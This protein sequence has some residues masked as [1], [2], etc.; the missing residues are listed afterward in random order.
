MKFSQLATLRKSVV[1]PEDFHKYDAY[2]GYEHFTP[3][4]LHFNTPGAPSTV[5]SN[6]QEFRP[7]DTIYGRLRPYFRKVGWSRQLTGICSTDFWVLQPHPGV[8]PRFVFYVAG[9][10]SFTELANSSSEGTRMP[11]ASWAVVKDFEVPNF[12]LREQREIAATL[13]ALDD[14]IESNQLAI[15]KAQK[16][17]DALFMASSN[18]QKSISAVGTITMGTSPKGETLNEIGEGVPFYQGTR[19]FG[20]R[21]P[22]LR[23][24][25]ERPIRRAQKN[26][27]LLS[28][29]APVGE[30]NRALTDCCIGRGVAAIHNDS[31]PSTLYYAMRA[32]A[33]T[34]DR[35]QGEGTVF[36]SVNKKDVHSAMIRWA[37]D[38][39]VETLEPMLAALDTRIESLDREIQ[40]L[41]QLRDALLPE[42]LAGRIKAE[43]IEK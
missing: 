41:S 9:S 24:W 43:G 12:S 42:L 6:K 21:F 39:S 38:D 23:V 15:T 10:Q 4:T 7:G 16:L 13:G 33:S 19:D 37:S 17:G 36:A 27:T 2:L 18:E 1:R 28:V 14:K 8:D 11:R 34:W 29:R 25:T 31:H 20:Y 3:G 32:S 22:S 26:D 5:T 35:F 40:N 30:L